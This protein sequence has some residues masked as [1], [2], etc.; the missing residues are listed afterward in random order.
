MKTN[1]PEILQGRIVD[2]ADAQAVRFLRK[3]TV[4]AMVGGVND[5]TLWRKEQAGDFPRRIRLSARLTVWREDQVLAW[6][7]QQ[8]QER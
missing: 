7:E 6:M 2:D 5:S 8:G 4:L 3:P 1:P